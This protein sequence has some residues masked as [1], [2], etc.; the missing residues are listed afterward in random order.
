[1]DLVCHSYGTAVDNRLLREL[2]GEKASLDAGRH[3]SLRP[4][5][6]SSSS[7]SST[8]SHARL[9]P[10]QSRSAAA[11]DQQAAGKK[12]A[13]GLRVHYAALLDP[14]V[15]GGATAGLITTINA[16]RPDISFAYCANRAGVTVREVLDFD[17]RRSGQCL[18]G[19]GVYMSFD[20][21][22]LD[23]QLASHVLN[24]AGLAHQ[25]FPGAG[26]SGGGGSESALLQDG[27]HVQLVVDSTPRSFHGRWLLELWYLGGGVLWRSPCA[28]K[29]LGMLR[30]RVSAMQLK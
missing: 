4:P 29:A 27:S 12:Q 11:V 7:S 10:R 6:S 30:Q 13:A 16:C 26:G 17:P 25:F 14:I 24:N 22:L 3:A 19:L 5:A 9:R 28:S 21:I 2:C 15:L 18:G 20:D 1:V 23:A 8:P